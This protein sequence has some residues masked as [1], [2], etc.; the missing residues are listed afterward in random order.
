[1]AMLRTGKRP[2]ELDEK[3]IKKNINREARKII[4]GE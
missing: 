2:E 3:T 1:M 4:F